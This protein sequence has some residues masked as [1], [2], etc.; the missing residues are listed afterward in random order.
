MSDRR[1]AS[2]L[3]YRKLVR[4]RVPHILRN[5]GKNPVTRELDNRELHK[6]VGSKILEESH[7][8]FRAW[9]EGRSEKILKES[10]D[11]LEV[12]LRALELR[13]YDLQDLL[14]ARDRHRLERGGFSRNIFLESVGDTDNAH[15]RTWDTPGFIF[16][17]MDAD[18]LL[19][20][21]KSELR[22][23]RD[24][25][26]ASA[27]YSPAVLNLLINDFSR[28]LES[29]NNL[30]VLLSTMGNI[31]RPEH[32]AHLQSVLPGALV[33]VFHPPDVPLDQPPPHFHP[34]I[35]LFRHFDGNGSLIIGSANFTEA[36]FRKNIEWSYYS[37]GEVNLPFDGRS[38]FESAREVFRRY[39]EEMSTEV[40]AEFLDAYA[41]RWKKGTSF[42][43]PS[44]EGMA[45]TSEHGFFNDQSGYAATQISPN[46]A[47]RAALKKLA[48]FRQ[49]GVRRASVIAATGVG[50]TFL[51]AFDF[52]QSGFTKLL[53]IAHRESL[54]HNARESFRKVM[55]DPSFGGFLGGGKN[56]VSPNGS[57]FAMIQTLRQPHQLERFDPQAFEYIVVDEFHHSEA[58]TYK[59]VLGHFNPRFLLGLTATPERLD[60]RDVL[61]FC[62][63]NIA[64]EVRLLEAVDNGWLAPFQYYAVYDETDYDQL[65]WKGA[66]YDEAELSRALENDTRTSIVA[67]NLRKFLPWGNK[68][69][70]LAFCSSVSHARYTAE[71]LTNLHGIPSVALSGED[72]EFTR[73]NVIQRLQADRDPL[74]VICTV[75]IFNEGIDIPELS[76]LLFLRPTQSFTVF[77]QQLGRGLRLCEGKEYLVVIDFVGNF[78]K[79]HVAPLALRGYTS[80]EHFARH[81]RDG[82]KMS[83]FPD[84]CYVDADLDVTRIW[85]EEIRKIIKG[86]LSRDELLKAL[87]QEIKENL[88]GLSPSL[89]DFIGNSHDVDPYVFI[90]H[91]EGW[92]RTRLYCE[93]GLEG[94]ELTLLDTPAEEFLK[95][96]EMDLKPSKSYKMVVLLTLLH[97]SGTEWQ[98][99]DIARGF[100][101]H[102]L[103]HP[104]RLHD[105]DELARSPHPHQFPLR[106]VVTK[107][108]TMPLKFLSNQATDFFILDRKSGIFRLK[109]QLVDFWKQPAF[110][111]MVKERV[112]FAMIRYF[113]RRPHEE[114]KG[115]RP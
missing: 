2:S 52:M 9:H 44:S 84:A 65:T 55:V 63:Y 74:Q 60:G 47:Q 92:L 68:T 3:T 86:E 54:L 90:R 16:S 30:Q 62:D 103:T 106:K 41:K 53:F 111:S 97:L 105:Y 6:A 43:P 108:N 72:P 22:Q 11:V 73:Q 113:A 25:W 40:T 29:G 20:L 107:L 101:N 88:D 49:A 13:G 78:R 87:Y 104:D 26:I 91:F 102:Y 33:K 8:L 94:E 115:A 99:E 12:M 109:P 79:A 110:K 70:A 98:V 45:E 56:E 50:K 93:E 80:G 46:P 15:E 96:I 82:K 57:L 85:D 66:R 64:Y 34:K 77:L 81:I 38:P 37:S 76:H 21:I 71:R 35:Y 1:S 89:L 48:E 19:Q 31:N 59:R 39:W 23:S 17:P 95:H 10:A 42:E 18:G 24:A 100:F 69:K 14:A 5:E 36:G 83:A 58:V 67:T 27:F 51:A 32:L 28:F 4:D 7:E 114:G 112:E 75:D 61:A